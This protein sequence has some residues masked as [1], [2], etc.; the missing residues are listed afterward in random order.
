MQVE[1]TR[2][3]LLAKK[4]KTLKFYPANASG[5]AHFSREI[6]R[7]YEIRILTDFT[8]QETALNATC[9]CELFDAPEMT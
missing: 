5:M 8:F 4:W 2:L 9:D 6:T 7:S 3:F 1:T